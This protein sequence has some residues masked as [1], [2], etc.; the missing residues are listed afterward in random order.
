M[1]KV[2]ITDRNGAVLYRDDESTM[3]G[4]LKVYWGWDSRDRVWLYN[5]DDGKI[6]RW[7]QGENGWM[8]IESRRA[9]GIPDFVLPG[10]AK[11]L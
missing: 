8:K 4:T 9:D 3:V 1:W 11:G 5:S 6:W 7:E 2:T 10:Y